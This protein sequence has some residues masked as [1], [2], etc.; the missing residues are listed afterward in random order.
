[1]KNKL[2]IKWLAVGLAVLSFA[3]PVDAVTNDPNAAHKATLERDIG[4]LNTGQTVSVSYLKL[5]AVRMISELEKSGDRSLLPY[6]AE[7][8]LNAANPKTVR[9]RAA[10]AFVNIADLG[11]GVDFLQKYCA[12]PTVKKGKW[13]LVQQYLD[14]YGEHGINGVSETVET[15]VLSVLLTIMQTTDVRDVANRINQ[16][17]LRSIPQY[18]NSVQR[19][20]LVRFA[21]SG[22]E[23]VTNT[24]HPIKVHFDNIPPKQ[25]TDLRDRFPDLP[26][27]PGDAPAGGGNRMKV[28]IAVS[29]GVVA[30][31]TVWFAV[32]R[33]KARKTA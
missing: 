14:K 23:W 6:L 4:L 13:L 8:S 24:F 7:K 31:V 29:V 16:H 18:T 26:P 12:D 21:T 25:R 9:R 30:V 11:E 19:A 33:K 22:N 27:L 17:L 2:C 5:E 1:M 20:S 3:R 32:R 15:H 10:A 28:A